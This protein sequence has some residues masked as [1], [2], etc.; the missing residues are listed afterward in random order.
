MLENYEINNGTLAIIPINENQSQVYEFNN[1][2]IVNSDVKTIINNSCKYFGSSFIGRYEGS[3]TLLGM[4][5][6]LP[7]IIEETQEIIFFP[8]SSPRF[9]K[10]SWISLKNIENYKEE[11]NK[12]VVNFKTGEN[13]NFNLSIFSFENQVFRAIRLERILKRRKS[14]QK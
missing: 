1:K 9:D 12:V 14:A 4:N 2:Y 10:C 13:V 7:I 8:T 11:N 3:K 6:K 5:Y